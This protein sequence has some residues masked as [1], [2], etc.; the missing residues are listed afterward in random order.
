LSTVQAYTAYA[1]TGTVQV[2]TADGTQCNGV[3]N[4]DFV[5]GTDLADADVFA[6]QQAIIAAFPTAWGVNTGYIQASK[7]GQSLTLYATDYTSTP[8]TFQ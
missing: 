4:L 2:S 6:I 7:Q 3:V 5:A 1:V 8:P